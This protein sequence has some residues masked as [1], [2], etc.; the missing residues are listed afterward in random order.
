MIIKELFG[1]KPCG[2]EVYSYTLKN[3]SGASVKIITLGA[4][5]VSIN[6]PDKNNVFADVICGYDDVNSY[7]TNSGY[8]GAIIGRFGNRISNSCFELDGNKYK[9][10]NNEGNNHLHGGKIGFDKKVWDAN[11][12]EI[13]NTM[14]LELSCL[15]KDMEEGY[16]GNLRVKVLYTFDNENVFS[17]NY[18]ATTDKKTVLNLTNHAYF[19]LGGYNSGRIENHS[20]WIDSEKISIIDEKLIPTGEELSVDGTPFDF[21]V[22]KLIGKDIDSENTILKYGKG[23]DHNFILNSNGTIKHSI[24]LKDTNSGRT[25]K[26]YTNQHCVQVYTAN[27]INESE[28]SFKNGVEQRI[29]CAVCLETQHA[30][31]SPNRP[32]FPSCVLSPGELYDYTT[33]FKFEK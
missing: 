15:S 6:I 13:G 30:P 28:S 33:V 21:R 5:I 31:D 25:M 2:C 23:Y 20:L 26:V 12:W 18:K 32:E 7:L 24:T 17:I 19:N 11:A 22:E 4:T 16:P 27:C 1:K 9:L 29:R 14:Y 8:Q 3:K 10:Y